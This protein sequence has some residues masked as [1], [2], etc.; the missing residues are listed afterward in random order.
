MTW[1][2]GWSEAYLTDEQLRARRVAWVDEHRPALDIALREF[3]STG[4]WPERE[5]LR[6]VLVQQGIGIDLDELLRT[7]PRPP[8]ETDPVVPERV[9]LPLVVLQ[10]MPGAGQLL[11]V[12]AAMVRRAF[13]LYGDPEVET[14]LLVGD[15]PELLAAADGNT[16][17]L[18]LAKEVLDRSTPRVFGGGHTDP[19]DPTAWDGY[20]NEAAMP[21]FASVNTIDDFLAAQERMMRETYDKVGH[22][23]SGQPVAPTTRRIEIFVLMSFSEPWSADVYDFI[24]RASEQM[25]AP[26]EAL[27]VYR[28][29]DIAAPGRITQQIE[30]AIAGADAIVADITGQNGNV[31]WELGYAHALGKQAVIMNQR[32]AES[33]FDLVD[34]RQYPYTLELSDD[35]ANGLALYLTAALR[36]ALGDMGPEWLQ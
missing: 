11:V 27:H 14:P 17:L 3:L 19:T 1:A 20:L 30:D 25:G 2:G 16:M 21:G 15:D 18:R 8:W 32:P 33:P 24:R 22:W 13:Q 34:R 28:A 6:R 31:M 9:I 26:E 36:A 12:C 35:Q 7:T 10:V 5:R 29:D 4:E 23:P